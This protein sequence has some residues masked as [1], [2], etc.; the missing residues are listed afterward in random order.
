MYAGSGEND[1]EADSR[2][3][4]AQRH[5]QYARQFAGGRPLAVSYTRSGPA[6]DLAQEWMKRRPSVIP[7]AYGITSV[8]YRLGKPVSKDSM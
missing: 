1:I 2:M 7:D 4:P 3:T 5:A 6:A 8:M